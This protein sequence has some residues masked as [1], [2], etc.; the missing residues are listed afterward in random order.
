[1]KNVCWFGLLIHQEDGETAR[2]R[3]SERESPLSIFQRVDE[4]T[5]S[6][7]EARRDEEEGL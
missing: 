6:V 3:E 5:G 1:M 7:E 4:R 2:E